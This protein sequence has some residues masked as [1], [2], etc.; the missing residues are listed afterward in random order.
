M[1]VWLNNISEKQLTEE[2]HVEAN[3]APY[4]R[5]VYSLTV[6]YAV[7]LQ[8]KKYGSIGFNTPYAW[9]ASDIAICI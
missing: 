6:F 4:K 3:K 2:V 9:S 5:L 8:R 1:R 7:L